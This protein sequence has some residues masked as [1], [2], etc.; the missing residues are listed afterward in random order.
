MRYVGP[1]RFRLSA[2]GISR[3]IVTGQVLYRDG[4]HTGVLPGKVLRSSRTRKRSGASGSIIALLFGQ[5]GC[6]DF[7]R[8]Q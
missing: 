7:G 5:S 8:I 6:S 3:V 1:T 4:Q 2:Q